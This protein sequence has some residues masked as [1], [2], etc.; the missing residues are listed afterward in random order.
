M[1]T[2]RIGITAGKGEAT[3]GGD[4]ACRGNA[5]ICTTLRMTAARF[6]EKSSLKGMKTATSLIRLVALGIMISLMASAVRGE[7]VNYYWS[8]NGSTEG[9]SGTWDTATPHFSTNSSGPFD[10]AWDNTTMASDI[11]NFRGTAGT[12]DVDAAGINCRRVNVTVSG[13]VLQGGKITS[14]QVSNGFMID[15]AAA[16]AVTIYNDFDM[17]L[18]GNGN[19]RLRNSGG[20]VNP[21]T[22]GGTFRFLDAA[23]TK[24]LD[25]EG[26]GSNGSRIDFIG[27]LLNT[28]GAVIRLRLGQA[29]TGAANDASVYNLAGSSSHAGGTHVVRGTVNVL[30]PTA[31]GVGGVQLVTSVTPN[32]ATVRFFVVGDTDLPPGVSITTANPASGA[33]VTA[34]F[35]KRAGDVSTTTLNGNFNLNADNTQVEVLVAE[36]GARLNFAGIIADGTGI[37]GFTKTGAGVLALMNPFA[38]LYDGTTTVSAGTLLV[39]NVNGS[40]TGTGAVVVNSGATLAGS[41]IL[42]GPVTVY[43]ILAPGASIGTL[44]V[45]NDVTLVAG[46]TNIMEIHKATGPVY[47]ADKL[48]VITGT[49][50]LGGTLVVT[51]TGEPLAAGDVFDL[52]DGTL[53]GSFTALVLPE[54]PP[55]T[56]WDTSQLAPGGN[57]TITL[58]ADTGALVL[59]LAYSPSA[60]TVTFQ[61]VSGSTYVVQRAAQV[62]GPWTNLF[63]TNV[64]PSGVFQYLDGSPLHPAAFYRLMIP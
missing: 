14:D 3:A 56:H 37:R 27:S 28:D 51:A 18:A 62:I 36:A 49:L 58:V 43:G 8:A 44:T 19:I 11:A 12:I 13:Y 54:A 59:G 30:S 20:V 64:P 46:S 55:G 5:T 1:A 10:V 52:F 45:T 17:T 63:T 22:L 23:G 42:N 31:L 26:T 33:T 57:G 6:A 40:A 39:S 48:R 47:T 16:N 4:P 21:L 15:K 38:S 50:T 35:G 53:A 7:N 32:G 60:V 24:Y 9:G 2:T 61:G 34:V 41:G 25:L 29:G